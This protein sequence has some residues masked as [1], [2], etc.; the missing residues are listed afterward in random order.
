MHIYLFD[1]NEIDDGYEKVRNICKAYSLEK[2]WESTPIAVNPKG[3]PYFVGISDLHFSISHT[4]NVWACAIDS[5]PLGFDIE[6]VDRLKED[7]VRGPVLKEDKWIKLAKRFYTNKEYQYILS[8]GRDAFLQIWVRKEAYLKYKGTGLSPG[9][10]S[11]ELIEKGR[12]ISRLANEWVDGINLGPGLVSA[13]CSENERE[14]DKIVDC[15]KSP[16]I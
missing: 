14:I 4:K 12:L 6:E 5:Q 16:Y 8:G 13:Y 2:E 3:K 11:I 10:N 1:R 7:T 15:R 9:L